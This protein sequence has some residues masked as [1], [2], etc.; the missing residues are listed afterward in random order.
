MLQNSL[1]HTTHPK[2]TGWDLLHSRV[3]TW[4]QRLYYLIKS[5]SQHKV[6][7]ITTSREESMDDY[8]TALKST[9]Q[10]W[11]KPIRI[12]LARAN[13]RAIHNFRPILPCSWK[14]RS[15]NFSELQSCQQQFSCS[16]GARPSSW[17]QLCH[18][19]CSMTCPYLLTLLVLPP[20]LKWGFGIDGHLSDSVPEQIYYLC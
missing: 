19:I 4:R 14:K 13:Y 1:A 18:L 10:K 6:S 17:C 16:S 20:P 2:Q 8:N 7:G 11:Q 3:F 9:V 12:L 5:T 15:R